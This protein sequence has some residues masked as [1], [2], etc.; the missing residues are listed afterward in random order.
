M[1]D[2]LL[3]DCPPPTTLEPIWRSLEAQADVSFFTSWT[4]IGSWLATLPADAQPR[5][6]QVRADGDIAGLALLGQRKSRR[7]GFVHSRGLHVNA[8]GDPVADA[9]AIEYNSFLVKR[10]DT[11]RLQRAMLNHLVAQELDWD[12][13]YLP[14]MSTLPPD[15][16]QTPGTHFKT[17]VKP[18]FLVDLAQVREKNGDYPAALSQQSRYQIRKSEK[19]FAKLGP[20][21][22]AEAATLEEALEYLAALK[23]LHQPYW[24]ARGEPGAFAS[25]FSNRF[26]QHLITH[27]FPRKEVQLLR[28]TVGEQTLG[29]LYN[30]IHRGHVYNYQTG[31]DYDMLKGSVSPGLVCHAKAVAHCALAGLDIYDFMA[32]EQRYKRSMSTHSSELQW[33]VLQR[34]KLRFKA[35]DALRRL[36]QHMMT[37]SA[38]VDGEKTSSANA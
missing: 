38:A 36:K 2:L 25:D 26:H 33:S 22:L 15:V 29:Y 4:W 3:T 13:L 16:M 32:G 28:V 12:E 10:H 11:D 6:L 37:K 24:I 21:A 14:G 27:A 18:A 23:N 8:S 7:H 31:I 1:T 35:E 5:L 19:A 17:E 34:D 9:I 20:I 30:F